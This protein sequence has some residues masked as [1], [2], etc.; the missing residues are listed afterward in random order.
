MTRGKNLVSFLDKGEC[1]NFIK[2]AI[3]I[4]KK[5]TLCIQVWIIECSK[6]FKTLVAFKEG[7]SMK[8]VK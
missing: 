3:F 5:V 2:E 1:T 6:I 7:K 8:V 4:H